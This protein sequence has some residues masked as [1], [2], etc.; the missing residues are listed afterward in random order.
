M[1]K[2]T[3]LNLPK[4]KRERIIEIAIEE[5]ASKPYTKASL[6]NIVNRAGIAKGSMYQYFEDKRALFRYLLELAAQEKLA[7][8]KEAEVNSDVNFFETLEKVMLAGFRFNLAHPQLSRIVANAM[9]GTGE[10]VIQEFMMS[11][12]KMACEY[13]MELLKRGQEGGEVSPDVNV[14]LTANLLNR[15]L[16]EGLADYI[17]EIMEVDL[18]EFLT[19][20]EIAQNISEDT[21]KNIVNEAI[22]FLRNGLEAQS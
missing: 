13:F 1:V 21:I 6:S 7:F 11:G 10:A 12:R 2:Q 18:H 22:R 19:K 17:L 9:E 15:I 16:G 20:P 4:E 5:F 3:F 14:R 8:L